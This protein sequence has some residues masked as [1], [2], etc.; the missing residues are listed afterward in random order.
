[1]NSILI[2]RDDG[3]GGDLTTLVAS[4]TDGSLKYTDTLATADEGKTF[5]VAVVATNTIGGVTSSA[6]SFVLASLPAAPTPVPSADTTLTNIN[7][8]V[9]NFEN[10][11]TDTGGAPILEYC[12]QMDD[13]IGGEFSTVF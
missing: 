3:A 1:M 5:R 6:T 4:I 13:G 12:L 8:I 10:T 9:V 2:Y 11:N 7:Q